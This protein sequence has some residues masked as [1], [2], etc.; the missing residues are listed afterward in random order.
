ESR[1]WQVMAMVPAE[2]RAPISDMAAV[3]QQTPEQVI[4]MFDG[5]IAPFEAWR[6]LHE[7]GYS[8]DEI[9][10]VLEGLSALAFERAQRAGAAGS[11][12]LLG[13]AAQ[14]A[15]GA[16]GRSVEGNAASGRGRRTPPTY[17]FDYVVAR[18]P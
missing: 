14:R 5:P 9:E 12:G 18:A 7:S 4:G 3:L 11:Q 10:R 1:V 8:E 13:D 16:G 15:S 2:L 6:A 17:E